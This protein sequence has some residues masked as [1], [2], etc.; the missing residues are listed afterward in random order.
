VPSFQEFASGRG[1]AFDDELTR[2]M[3]EAF[4]AVCAMCPA[5]SD[6]DREAIAERIISAA[7]AGERDRKR[8]RN[9]GLAS[10]RPR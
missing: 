7:A 3:G 10:L 1:G 8:L 5:L 4:D 2:L 9:V 6:R